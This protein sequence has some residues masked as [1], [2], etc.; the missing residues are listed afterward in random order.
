MSKTEATRRA[1]LIAGGSLTLLPATRV[2]S[3]D[4]PPDHY[5]DPCHTSYPKDS[6]YVIL[7]KTRG[8]FSDNH[9]KVAFD[10]QEYDVLAATIGVDPVVHAYGE[11]L[12]EARLRGVAVKVIATPL[13]LVKHGVWGL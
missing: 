2:F 9:V 8:F 6:P 5:P 13:A 3:C 12:I 4:D 11:Q 10:P 1:I 7:A